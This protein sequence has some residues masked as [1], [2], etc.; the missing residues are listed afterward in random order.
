MADLLPEEQI[1]E[2]LLAFT[3][4]GVRTF[5]EEHSAEPFYA[6]AY[7]CNAEYGEVNLCFNT[8]KDF[9][10]TLED[11]QKNYPEDYQKESEIEE[12]KYNTGD[13]THQCFDTHYIL[14]EDKIAELFSNDEEIEK[15]VN[16]L[17]NLFAQTLLAFTKTLEY[18]SIPKTEDFKIICI[19]HDEGLEDAVLRLNQLQQ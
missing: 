12:L 13:W 17:M 8:E 11:Y 3:K 6:F 16:R 15:Q 19:D 5:L 2:A 18:Q 14:P 7:D 10:Q 9:K 4:N 1:K